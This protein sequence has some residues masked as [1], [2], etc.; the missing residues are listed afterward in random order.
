MSGFRPREPH[1]ADP[2]PPFHG[3]PDPADRLS[4][5]PTLKLSTVPQ[6]QRH[7]GERT[8]TSPL[9]PTGRR[10]SSAFD[11][12]PSTRHGHKRTAS[13]RPAWY[14]LVGTVALVALMIALPTVLLLGGPGGDVGGG[15]TLAS[16]GTDPYV[17]QPYQPPQQGTARDLDGLTSMTSGARLAYVNALI[18]H[19][20]L[21]QEIGQ[22]TMIGFTGTTV[23]A[24]V[25]AWIKQ[26]QPGSIILYDR[27]LQNQT[28]AQALITQL[29][30]VSNVPMYIMVDQEGGLVDRMANIAGPAPSA[31]WLGAQGNLALAKEQ[32]V[33]DA[34]HMAA[35]GVNV[36]LAP[37]V[38]VSTVPGGQGALTDRTFGTDPTL[39]TTMAGAYLAGLQ[40][41][42]HV[43]GVL[44][45]FPGLGSAANDPHKQLPTV[46]KS[47]TQI[48]AVDWAPYKAL[49]ASGQVHMIMTTHVLVPALDPTYPATISGTITTDLLRNTLGYQGVITTDDVF[50]G[51]M[52]L[53]YPMNEVF[54]RAVLAGN[55]IICCTWGSDESAY[56]VST[57]Q[58]DVAD[59]TIGKA[60]ID[61]SVRRILL[62]KMQLGLPMPQL[63]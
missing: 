41:S 20:T 3:A 57:L 44:K 22:L 61:E 16:Q 37:V 53:N 21:D 14:V 25:A 54:T 11:R 18:S 17:R 4:A 60:R 8:A 47:R 7:A 62:L 2:R 50:M 24:G 49:I 15:S 63:G 29:Q 56:F 13:S 26:Y 36:N 43:V 30:A 38:D 33:S 6:A 28:Q 12:T 35:V 40:Q 27:N 52:R 46:T 59:G 10:P 51:A 31:Q 9:P 45:H 42:G 1:S 5:Q 23:D 48:E 55:D 58:G 19:M 39:V 34:A 32:G